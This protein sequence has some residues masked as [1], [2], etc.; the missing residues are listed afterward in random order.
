[1]SNR[2]LTLLTFIAIILAAVLAYSIY[3]QDILI[4]LVLVL[5]YIVRELVGL[6][7]QS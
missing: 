7:G 4:I 6:V 2:S 3:R 5:G 1:M